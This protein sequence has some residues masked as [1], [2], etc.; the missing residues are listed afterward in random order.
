[1]KWSH[2]HVYIQQFRN[3]VYTYS[4]NVHPFTVPDLIDESV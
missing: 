3:T 1:M 4:K 2:I